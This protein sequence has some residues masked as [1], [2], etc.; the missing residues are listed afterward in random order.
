MGGNRNLNDVGGDA[1]SGLAILSGAGS[2]NLVVT[3]FGAITGGSVNG[4]AAFASGISASTGNLVIN[5]WGA[6]NAGSGAST[7]TQANFPAVAI[8]L[9]GG[10]NMMNLNG[11]SSVNGTIQAT[12]V[13]DVLNLN[14]TGMTPAAIASLKAQLTAEGWPSTNNFT[15]TFTVRRGHLLHGRSSCAEPSTVS[16][17]Y[18]LPGDSPPTSRQS[19]RASTAS[20]PTL[21]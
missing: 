19:A 7:A 17:S 3:N 12:G 14:F 13:N 9:S 8:N 10:N 2:G 6:V 15:G 21:F 5:N 20:P 18:Q 16:S 1:A 4:N 11:H